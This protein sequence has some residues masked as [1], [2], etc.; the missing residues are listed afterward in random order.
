MRTAKTLIRLADAQADLSL[1][2][3]H[4]HFVG[5]VMSRLISISAL[6]HMIT[7]VRFTVF[8]TC[9]GGNF[10]PGNCCCKWNCATI[11]QKPFSP[12]E[13]IHHE[14]ENHVSL[15]FYWFSEILAQSFFC[16]KNLGGTI[17][18]N[19][20][21]TSH[22]CFVNRALFFLMESAKT[23]VLNTMNQTVKHKAV[24]SSLTYEVIAMQKLTIQT[25]THG[26]KQDMN[27]NGPGEWLSFWR[28]TS[29]LIL[30]IP[31]SLGSLYCTI[32]VRVAFVRSSTKSSN[33]SPIQVLTAIYV[34]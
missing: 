31:R 28:V 2:W 29:K 7:T 1:P 26:I 11:H 33:R 16:R 30:K 24:N 21:L 22:V 8:S 13:N 17:R 34:A 19:G 18:K 20:K 32:L 15:T 23:H 10:L 3:A 6:G 12:T 9:F 4:S 14:A 27:L 5:F 25:W